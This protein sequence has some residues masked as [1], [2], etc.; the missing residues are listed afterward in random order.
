[1]K[2]EA[3]K[4]LYRLARQWCSTLFTSLAQAAPARLTNHL[5]I[6]SV[7]K[8][9]HHADNEPTATMSLSSLASLAMLAPTMRAAA[10]SA[11]GCAQRQIVLA[12]VLSSGFSLQQ[13]ISLEIIN[14]NPRSLKMCQPDLA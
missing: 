11:A 4:H 1:M 14:V 2:A 9:R 8:Q 12:I 13:E 5:S 6:S 10:I 3:C 7:Q